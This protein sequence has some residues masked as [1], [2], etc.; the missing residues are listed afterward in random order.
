MKRILC[1]L[2]AVL[3]LTACQ[4]KNGYRLVCRQSNYYEFYSTQPIYYDNGAW[5]IQGDEVRVDALLCGV[6]DLNGNRLGW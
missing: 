4:K 1:L 6:D 3:A 2:V 5:V